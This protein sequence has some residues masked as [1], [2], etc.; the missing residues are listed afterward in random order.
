MADHV[1][2]VKAL[3]ERLKLTQAKLAEAV[4]VDQSTVSN[5]EKHV[6]VPRGPARKLLHSLASAAEAA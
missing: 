5:W 1:I 6:T 3:R 4:G 2:D